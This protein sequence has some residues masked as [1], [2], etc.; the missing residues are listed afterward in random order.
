[1]S[2]INTNG[3]NVNYPIP[4]VNN[5]SQGFR[6]N[7]ASI[8]TNLDTA[9]TE[10]TD[11]QNKVVVK[12][13]LTGTTVNNDMA[14]TLISNALTRSFRASMYN[15]GG[16]LSGVVNINASLGDVLYGTINGNT[17]LTFSNWPS[18]GTQA[19]IEIQLTVSNNYSIT[20][21]SS[22]VYNGN[23][24][25]STIENA[26]NSGGNLVITAPA[27]VTQLN[28]VIS[29]IDC[30]N[31]LYITPINRPRQSTQI[32]ERLISPK[33]FQGDVNGDVAVGPSF[34]QIAIS[35]TTTT[36]NIFT[37]TGNTVQLYTDL[38]I[39]FTGTTFGGPT[40]GQTYYVRNVV[41]SNTFTVSSTLGGANISL[42]TASGTMYANPTGY[43]YI[44]TD[45]YNS[46][47]YTTAVSQTYANGMVTLSGNTASLANNS[48]II[49]T[50][51][52][53]GLVSNTVY[54]VKSFT[55]ANIFVSRSRTAGV[56][57]STVT[58]SA[59]TT[60]TTATFYV[61]NDIW[62]RIALTSW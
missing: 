55:G 30:G 28:Y 22:L 52:M 7:F 11:L 53:G 41:S 46:T 20:F 47:A 59:N 33:G 15:L 57:D 26:T 54:Y 17:S 29:T 8:K 40:A 58:L 21:P 45:A 27:N 43:I 60:A 49:F 62:K 48:P 10:I 3:I 44:A 12:Q 5:N 31:S 13:A 14:N 6:N 1:M 50:A 24:G 36:S 18:A 4:G 2:S 32:Q 37:T 61:G 23:L 16:D 34:D 25:A 38:P 51:N 35:N 42:T 39:V 9:A 19:N 56:A